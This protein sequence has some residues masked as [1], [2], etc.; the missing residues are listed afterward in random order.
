MPNTV[1]SQP[2][3]STPS[4]PA[5]V[6][7]STMRKVTRRLVVLLFIAYVLN[8]L[9]RTNLGIAKLEMSGDLGL[10]E[11]AFGLGAGI[12]FIGYA[13][14]EIPSNMILH[15]VGARVWLAR[16]VISWGLIA[17]GMAWVNSET[18]F[19][20]MRFLLGVAEAGFVPGVL[21]Y[22]NSWA[23]QRYRAGFIAMFLVA[24]PL[25]SVIGNPLGGWLLTQSWFG[26]HSWH[27]LFVVEGVPT[28]LLGIFLLNKLTS[29]PS[30]AEWLEPAE[31]EWLTREIEMED[32][33]AR[34]TEGSAT[35]AGQAARHPR[36]LLMCLIYFA[37][38]VPVYSLAFF[39]PSMLDATTNGSLSTTAI[40]WL[41][42]FPYGVAAIALVVIA[43]SSDRKQERRLHYALPALAGAAGLVIAAL[44]LDAAPMIALMGITLGL[45]GCISVAGAFWSG[46][47]VGLIGA[48]AAMG[49][50]MINTSGNIGGFV[51]PYLSGW[52]MDTAGSARGGFLSLMVSGGFLATAACLMILFGRAPRAVGARA[53]AEVPA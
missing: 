42:A 25:A 4:A 34:V 39:L 2:A 47:S 37:T 12:F 36:V 27:L 44:T 22:L 43:R 50:A 51:S 24:L 21:L 6:E 46:A 33:A 7:R 52:L 11:A 18:S 48:A 1:R 9:D 19:Y 38:V 45:V 26:M 3:D 23:P 10:S 49:I 32:S 35:S 41:T 53:E 40:G 13:V 31:R 17:T 30:E 8:F 28:V 29:R 14:F 15:R 5:S 16:I 20:V